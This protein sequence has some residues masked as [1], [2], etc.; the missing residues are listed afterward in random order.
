M[1]KLREAI[2]TQKA[3]YKKEVEEITNDLKFM[4]NITLKIDED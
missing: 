4:A 2:E 1:A 3:D